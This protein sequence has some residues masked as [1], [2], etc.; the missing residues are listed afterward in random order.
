M[1]NRHNWK[2]ATGDS[3]R[4]CGGR[5]RGRWDSGLVIISCAGS[6]LAEK[7]S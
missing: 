5:G 6:W 2:P 7:S 3:C 4:R 1:T